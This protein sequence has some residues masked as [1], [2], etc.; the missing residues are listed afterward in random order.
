MVEERRV[1]TESLSAEEGWNTQGVPE[2]TT[3][4]QAIIKMKLLAA[5]QHIR[6]QAQEDE[7]PGGLLK[8]R[9]SEFLKRGFVAEDVQVGP[10]GF[11]VLFFHPSSF[12]ETDGDE[13]GIQQLR[14]SFGDG[15]LPEEMMKAFSKLSITSPRILTK[16]PNRLIQPFNS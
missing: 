13:F 10:S 5:T 14:E 7:W 3:F 12:T 1:P 4:A 9:V 2:L 8:S 6:A 16:P 11:L 15:K